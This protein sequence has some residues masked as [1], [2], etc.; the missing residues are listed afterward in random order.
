[1]KKNPEA[2]LFDLNGTMIDDMKYHLD[3]WFEVITKDLGAN[4]T[5]EELRSQMYGKNEEV[6][7]RIF[8]ESRF[9]QFNFEAISQAKE[10]RYQE[11]Y[12]PHLQLLPGLH[13]FLQSAKEKEIKMAIGSAAPPF[14]VDFVLDNLKIRDYFQVVVTGVNVAQSKPHPE[15]FLKAAKRLGVKPSSC[16]VF[17]DA[18]MGVEAA[19]RAGIECV[20]V[21]TMHDANEFTEFNNVRLFIEDFRDTRLSTHLFIGS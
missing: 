6:L 14:N 3:V 11:I 2:F 9:K 8:G 15:V 19:A 16:I 7:I 5:R 18:P 21:T 20:V 1:M 10:E 12:K 13:D 4:L 17:E